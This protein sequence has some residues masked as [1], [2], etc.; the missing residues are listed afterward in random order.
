MARQNTWQ[1]F[2]MPIMYKPDNSRCTMMAVLLQ[3][4]CPDIL[5]EVRCSIHQESSWR[6]FRLHSVDWVSNLLFLWGKWF[7]NKM[8]FIYGIIILMFFWCWWHTLL[9][10]TDLIDS[11]LVFIQCFAS[12]LLPASRPLSLSP[13]HSWFNIYCAAAKK[14]NYFSANYYG[15]AANTQRNWDNDFPEDWAWCF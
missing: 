11:K 4:R 9:W 1:H 6:R 13:A 7:V 8:Q 3:V 15:L 2:L 5:G 10:L 12:N 14:Y